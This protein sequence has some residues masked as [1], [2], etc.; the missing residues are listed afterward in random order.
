MTLAIQLFSMDFGWK[1]MFMRHQFDRSH[2]THGVVFFFSFE[3][4]FKIRNS[5]FS[6]RIELNQVKL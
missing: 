2:T 3:T 1:T 5:S 6:N 4:K